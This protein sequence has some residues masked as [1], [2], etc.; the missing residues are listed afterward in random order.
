MVVTSLKSNYDILLGKI[1]FSR[2]NNAIVSIYK[3]AARNNEIIFFSNDSFIGRYNKTSDKKIFVVKDLRTNALSTFPL[4]SSY[5]LTNGINI[6]LLDKSSDRVTKKYHFTGLPWK[7]KNQII[8]TTIAKCNDNFL[9]GKVIVK[10]DA[11]KEFIYPKQSEF[12]GLII[13][14]S[15]LK[16][17]KTINDLNVILDANI[18]QLLANGSIVYIASNAGLS[19][20][21]F[22]NNKLIKTFTAINDSNFKNIK[23]MVKVGGNLI[24][25]TDNHIFNL[26]LSSYKLKRISDKLNNINIVAYSNNKLFIG[27]DNGLYIGSY[28]FGDKLKNLE[29]VFTDKAKFWAVN[30]FFIDKNELWVGLGNGQLVNINLNNLSI[31][32]SFMIRKGAFDIRWE[33]YIEMWQ[34]ISFGT[35]VVNSFLICFITVIIALFM[36]TT[37]GYALSRFKFP[38]YSLFSSSILAVNMIPPLLILIPIYLMYIKV[39]DVTGVPLVGTYPGI[40]A[41]YATWFIPMT[42]WIL[43]SFFAAI[44]VEIEEAAII[45]GC[46]RFQ[47]FWKIALP[48]AMPGII[49]TGIYIFLLAWDELLFATILLPEK[50]MFTIPLGIKL[51]IGNH[52][53]R[54][55]LMMAAATVATLPVLI[56][57]FMVQR[58]FIKGL[59]AGAVK[60]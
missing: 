46:N 15:N 57:F 8:S 41:L 48:L 2:E 10:T 60:G 51:Y 31:N 3:N 55:D 28:S 24:L 44:P 54:F 6:Y 7:L 25:S 58:W 9:L 18:N 42:I 52:Q 56:L 35:Y 45:D 30:S 40:I 16:Y 19:I 38:G 50:N 39:T 33:N 49:A 12:E 53:N 21:D 20:Y 1:G 22:K 27:S 36:A 11:D 34:N 5:L 59:T 13:F 47:V 37:A 26:D 23:S 4:T 29:C 17:L 14:D 43:R 32:K